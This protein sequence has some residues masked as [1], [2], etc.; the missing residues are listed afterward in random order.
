[1]ETRSMIDQ[2]LHEASVRYANSW[3][4]AKRAERIRQ[5]D[6]ADLERE[7]ERVRTTGYD[8]GSFTHSGEAGT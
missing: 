6:Q 7:Q 3:T 2:R 1:M 8:S 4:L 5:R